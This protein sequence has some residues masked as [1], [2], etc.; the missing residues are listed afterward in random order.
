LNPRPSGL[1]RSAS[2]NCATFSNCTKI[3]TGDSDDQIKRGELL[4][5]E[6]ITKDGAIHMQHSSDVIAVAGYQQDK[7]KDSHPEP[8]ISKMFYQNI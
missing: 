2:V 8:G 5:L 3:D 4:F 1:Y 6:P 7:V